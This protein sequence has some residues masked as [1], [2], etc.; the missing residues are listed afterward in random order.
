VCVCDCVH[1]R[2]IK[3]VNIDDVK[4]LTTTTYHTYINTNNSFITINNTYNNNIACEWVHAHAS[5]VCRH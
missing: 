3:R 2:H 1:S 4:H 5:A